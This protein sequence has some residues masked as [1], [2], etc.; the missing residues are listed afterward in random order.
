VKSV[1]LTRVGIEQPPYRIIQADASRQ[2]GDA[3]RDPRRAAAIAK[4]T[5]IKQRALALPP[6]RIGLLGSIEERNSVYQEVAPPLAI[7]AARKALDGAGDARDIGLVVTSSCTGYMV[8]GWDVQLVQE[9]G[10]SLN[11]VRLPI[12]E[13]GCAGGVVA[14]ARA[15]DYLRVH[16]EQQALVIAA[17]ICSLAFHPLVESG[18][19]TSALIFAD[20]ACAALLEVDGSEPGA[21]LQIV[22]S[23]SSLIPCSRQALGFDLTDKGFYPVLTRELTEILPAA[24]GAAAC[25]LLEAHGLHLDEIAFW[26]I[27]P[28]GARILSGLEKQFG[29]EAGAFRWSW[30]S[31]RESGN[32][33]S[34][35]VLDL[36]RRYLDDDAAPRGWGVVM[37]FGPGVSLELLLVRR[38]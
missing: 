36:L 35:S 12:T 30:D 27:H 5:S 2:I 3:I 21:G 1:R 24:A 17:E 4:G 16:P 22:D 25:R 33:S 11:T 9:L 8:P 20:G 13:S 28:G 29:L 32:M 31:L 14:I 38:T 6:D 26:L 37:A 34:V 18:N 23:L 7:G 19:L 10:L 15:A